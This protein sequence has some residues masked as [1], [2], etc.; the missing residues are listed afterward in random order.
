[1]PPTKFALTTQSSTTA[2]SYST[3][4]YATHAPSIPYKEEPPLYQ[5]LYLCDV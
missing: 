4:K 3:R 2:K 5:P 1:M